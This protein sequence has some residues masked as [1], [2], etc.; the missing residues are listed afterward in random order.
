MKRA[1]CLILSVVML[2]CCG[3]CGKSGEVI[4]AVAMLDGYLEHIDDYEGHVQEVGAPSSYVDAYED[5]VIGIVYPE[6]E[7]EALNTAITEWVDDTVGVYKEMASTENGQ[8]E[9]AEL[10]VLYD[11]YNVNESTVAV[12][13]SGTFTTPSKAEPVYILKT[14]NY[15]VTN[16]KMMSLNDII[17]EETVETLKKAVVTKAEITEEKI[18]ENILQNIIVTKESID[19]ILNCGE[20][21]PTS[22]GVKTVSVPYS[23]LGQG[24]TETFFYK[25]PAPAPQAPAGSPVAPVTPVGPLTSTGGMIALTF[26]DGPSAHTERLLDIFKTHGGKGTFFVVGNLIDNRADT[27][28]RIVNEGHQIGSHSWSHKQLTAINDQELTD[29]LALTRQKILEVTGVDCTLVRPPYGAYNSN[30][31]AK[32]EQLGVH[33]VNWSIDTLDWKYRNATTVHNAIMQRAN[34]GAIVLCHD[35]HKTTV[36]AMETAIPQLIASGYQLVTVEELLTSTG[37]AIVPGALYNRR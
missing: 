12:K 27:V 8:A 32:G 22:E 26:D 36:D 2:L 10:S 7:I 15:D 4:E 35:L 9:L 3:G 6:T 16:Q 13:L 24:F 14:F 21:L 5:L 19:V 11:S 18:D 29:Q 30:V 20:Y 31:K 34:D 1:V 17:T 25:P 28:R 33:F 23:E 37:Q